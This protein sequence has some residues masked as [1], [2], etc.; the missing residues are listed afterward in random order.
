MHEGLE[1]A[2]FLK[3]QI[4]RKL[5]T[6]NETHL[7]F[8]A[9]PILTIP[10]ERKCVIESIPRQHY[11]QF[12]INFPATNIRLLLANQELEDVEM[13]EKKSSI[14]KWNRPRGAG[15]EVHRT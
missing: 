6:K 5:L 11:N 4:T 2:T 14:C 13:D 8:R 12:E 10:L 1:N 15:T 3:V 7:L 9:S